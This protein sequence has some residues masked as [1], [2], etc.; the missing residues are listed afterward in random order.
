MPQE[1]AELSAN[2]PSGIKVSLPD[3]SD[4]HNWKILL[5]GPKDT[6]F[7]VCYLL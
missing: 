5:E 2:P 3:E 4:L 6:P 7:A 1:L